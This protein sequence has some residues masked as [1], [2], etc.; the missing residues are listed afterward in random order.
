[1][2]VMESSGRFLLDGKVDVD[3]DETY[4]GEHDQGAIGRKGG[5]K[6]IVFL[7]IEKQDMGVSKMYARVIDSASKENLKGFM[8]DHIKVE[9]KVCT[10]DG[11]A[12]RVWKRNFL[13]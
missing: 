10:T 7:A 2:K 8:K 3:V 1:M 9:A 12:T 6:R 13:L 5:R 11:W 4:V